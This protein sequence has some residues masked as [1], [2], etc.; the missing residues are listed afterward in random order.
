[1]EIIRDE[2]NKITWPCLNC[3]KLHILNNTCNEEKCVSPRAYAASKEKHGE[4]VFRKCNVCNK[5]IEINEPHI[6]AYKNGIPAYYC[7][8]HLD[9]AKK[10][11]EF[12][13]EFVDVNTDC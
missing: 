13:Q 12:F 2:Y 8:E 1:M 9:G 10:Y 3:T 7:G 11:L 5:N 6:A 4:Y